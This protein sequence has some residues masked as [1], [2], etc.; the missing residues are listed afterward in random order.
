VCLH[1]R[2]L[3]EI[4]EEEEDDSAPTVHEEDEQRLPEDD[5]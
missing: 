2:R 3:G 5:L 4:E 1:Q